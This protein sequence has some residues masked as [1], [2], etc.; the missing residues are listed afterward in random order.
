[1]TSVKEGKNQLE[2]PVIEREREGETEGERGEEGCNNEERK[3]GSELGAEPTR[4]SRE[5]DQ[6]CV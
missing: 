3:R 5:R 2:T 4:T 6:V 1:M